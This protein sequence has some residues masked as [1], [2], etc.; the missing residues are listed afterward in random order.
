MSLYNVWL[1]PTMLHAMGTR[2]MLYS[3]MKNLNV[4]TPNMKP[5][6]IYRQNS[7]NNNR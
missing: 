3:D 2:H 1:V 4:R 7:V 6:D 5:H